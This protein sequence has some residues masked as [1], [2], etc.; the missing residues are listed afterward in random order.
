MAFVLNHQCG[1]VGPSS[2]FNVVG[3]VGGDTN[4]P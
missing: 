2:A 4:A 1:S 3:D